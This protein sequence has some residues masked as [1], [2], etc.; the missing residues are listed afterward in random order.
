MIVTTKPSDLEAVYY[1]EGTLTRVP[2]TGD[3]HVAHFTPTM[4][5]AQGI[6]RNSSNSHVRTVLDFLYKSNSFPAG[7]LD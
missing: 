2:L 3:G 5:D 1:H 4:S 6:E 7:P